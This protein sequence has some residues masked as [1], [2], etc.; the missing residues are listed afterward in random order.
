MQC[1]F[2][3]ESTEWEL[4]QSYFTEAIALISFSYSMGPNRIDVWISGG[5]AATVTQF[6]QLVLDFSVIKGINI[7]R[8]V[9]LSKDF[10]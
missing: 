4:T 1:D 3:P 8:Y 5:I 9:N 10:Y 2:I 7:I 6:D